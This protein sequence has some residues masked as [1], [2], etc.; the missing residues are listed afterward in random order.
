MPEQPATIAQVQ[1]SLHELAKVLRD[2]DHLEPEAQD[3]LA[4]LV[5]E[6]GKLLDP[7]TEPS[8]A[9]AHLATSAAT[10]ARGLHQRQNPTLLT[11]AKQRLERAALRAENE[12]P[13]AAGIVQ[14]LLD[15]LANLGI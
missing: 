13:L 14:R 5:D 9:A 10:L 12:A 6:L 1:T 2:A 7:S 3:A 4:D 11:A 8:A 15:A